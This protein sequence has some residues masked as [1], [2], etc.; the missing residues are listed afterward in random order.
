MVSAAAR[1]SISLATNACTGAAEKKFPKE[2]HFTPNND[3]DDGGGHSEDAVGTIC[4]A[5]TTECKECSCTEAHNGMNNRLY[6]VTL[7]L[8]YNLR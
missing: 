7:I 3:N 6:C 5:P 1:C 4:P 8:W 2:N